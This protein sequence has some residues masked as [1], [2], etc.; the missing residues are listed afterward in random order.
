MGGFVGTDGDDVIEGSEDDFDNIEGGAGNDTLNGN[1]GFD[2]IYGGDGDDTI[3]GGDG[4]DRL[5]GDNGNDSLSG[6]EGD[7]E[8]WSLSYAG[9]NDTLLDGG[10]GI[11]TAI[12]SR[13]DTTSALTLDISDPSAAWNLGGTTVVNVERIEYWG[14]TNV[15]TVTGGALDD[16]ITGREGNDILAGGAGNDEL[17]GETG[18]DTLRGGAGDDQVSGGEGN[19]LV[20]GGEGN[21]TISGWTGADTMRGGAGDDLVMVYVEASG[22]ADTLAEG[23]EG[24]DRLGIDATDYATAITIDL[25][26][27]GEFTLFGTNVSGFEDYT[28]NAG[29]GSDTLTGAAMDDELLGFAGDDELNGLAGNDILYGGDGDDIIRGGDG[30]DSLSGDGGA[31]VVDAG[32]GND[33]VWSTYEVGVTADASLEG[34][35]GIDYLILDVS[36]STLAQV[37]DISAA[38]TQTAHGTA[39]SGFEQLTFTGGSADDVVTGDAYGDWMQGLD[40]DDTLT[41]NG[42]D[43]ELHGGLGA[44]TLAGGVGA[45]TLFG[46]EG[47]D[48]MLGGEGDDFLYAQL[49]DGTADTLIDGGAGL[50]FA[51]FDKTSSTASLVYSLL[52]TGD[53]SV[54]GTTVRGIEWMHF[55]AGSGDDAITGG[56]YADEIYGNGGNDT[57]SGG[58]GDDELYGSTG[59]DV[60]DAGAG[61]DIVDG[62][63]GSDTLVLSG[64]RA[65]YRFNAENQ[66]VTV[67][68]LREGAP[69][70]VKSAISVENVRFA[71]GTFAMSA[72]AGVEVFG[73]EWNNN[74]FGTSAIEIIYGLSGDDF[75]RTGGGADTSFGGDGDDT[76]DVENMGTSS[77]D[78]LA[79]GGDGLDLL[80]GAIGRSSEGVTADFTTGNEWDLNGTIVRNFEQFELYLSSGDD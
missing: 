14:G 65:D 64:N 59:D 7:D 13:V 62:G 35:D 48:S 5:V 74:I 66:T 21:D 80:R 67:T 61:N 33:R 3:D 34:G 63:D 52:E 56:A 78:L 69:D 49:V 39:I 43:D 53:Q 40:G 17:F 37:I 1:G 68:D 38:T 41:G 4:N 42:G 18:N 73:T 72:V 25:S 70:G 44:D 76:I 10:A 20:E 30:E 2:Y 19:D 50:D 51:L 9:S 32:S 28:I 46:D 31:D 71:D 8:L 12:I 24:R 57:L 55:Y 45:D 29:S 26:A 22:S 60:L 15:D 16:V 75:I 23:G 11:D 6:G 58:A 79:D 27:G 36:Q 47:A 54:D 77:A